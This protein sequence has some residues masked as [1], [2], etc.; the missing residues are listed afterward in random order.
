MSVHHSRAAMPID[1]AALMWGSGGRAYDDISFAISDALKHGTERLAAR[2]GEAVL[3]LATGT[4][5]TARNIARYGARVHAVDF[6]R[7]LLEAARELSSHVRP[8]ITF[9]EANAE[10]LPFEDATFD[11]VI[12]T[13][14][15][16]FAQGQRRAAAELARV[17]KPGGRLVLVSWVPGG[18]VERFFALLAAHDD[19][20]PPASSPLAWGDPA[21]VGEL[22]GQTFDLL[23][24]PGTN[25][26][27]YDDEA[28]IWDWYAKGFGPVRSLLARL[29]TASS[30]ALRR[31]VDAYH[32][33]YRTEAG[34][35]V[36]RDYLVTIGRRR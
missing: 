17:C 19:T 25:H 7:P 10:R 12:S 8:P 14:G 20:P 29:D 21:E 30:A 36:E 35:H 13:F 26:A 32:A 1:P 2:P 24:E 28:A 4:G 11:R 31:A 16:M 33:A 23:F 34:L 27:W 6:A 5:W 9:Q 15:V 22:L 18:S 3:D